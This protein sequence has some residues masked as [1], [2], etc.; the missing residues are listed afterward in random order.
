MNG[1]GDV[2]DELNDGSLA[3]SPAPDSVAELSGQHGLLSRHAIRYKDPVPILR[4]SDPLHLQH[5]N[6]RLQIQISTVHGGD[7]IRR[8]IHCH[9][10][11]R[12]EEEEEKGEIESL[13]RG[14]EKL[15]EKRIYIYRERLFGIL[16]F[17]MSGMF[18]G[19]EEEE[20]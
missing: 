8:K 18:D 4:I 11:Y 15:Q 14:E 19:E 3:Q 2:I 17:W 6:Q 7:R 9:F 1:A 10:R 13:E 20:K 16:G 12:S 5:L